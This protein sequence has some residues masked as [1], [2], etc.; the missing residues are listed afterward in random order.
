L[1]AKKGGKRNHVEDALRIAPMD[2]L[3][4]LLG[5]DSW[6]TER[7]LKLAEALGDA[8]LDREFEIGH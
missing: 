4:R 8:Q 7:L 6:A 5:H 2:L 3:D 1:P